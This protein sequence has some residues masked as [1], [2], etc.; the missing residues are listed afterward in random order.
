MEPLEPTQKQDNLILI[1][2]KT[3]ELSA[4]E[5]AVD[6][7]NKNGAVSFSAL[8]SG[9]SNMILIAEITKVKVNGK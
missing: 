9:I 2:V 6:A 5:R 4:V 8:N 3:D 1:S 7:L